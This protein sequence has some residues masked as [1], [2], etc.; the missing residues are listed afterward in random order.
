MSAAEM[1]PAAAAPATTAG[2]VLAASVDRLRSAG[3]PTPRLD[4]EVLVAWLFERDRAWL[5]AHLDEPV[6]TAG[7]AT[8]D[9]WVNRRGRGE[10][11]A[12][13]RGF[14][15]WNGIRLLTDERALIPRPETELLV[16]AAVAEIA[17]RLVRDERAISAWDVGT[18]SGAV[19]VAL[20]RRFRSAL[21]LGRVRL[22]ASDV[23]PEAVE[24]ASDNLVAH[25]VE[26][27]VTLAVGDLLDADRAIRPDVLVAN[28]P[29]VT[30]GEVATGEGSLGWEP[31]TALDGGPDGLDV[32]RSLFD[33]L[34]G[35]LAEDGT[36]LLEVGSDQA[37]QVRR[38]VGGLPGS[39]AVSVAPDLAGRDRVVHLERRP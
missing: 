23:S 6:E 10:P 24:L 13:I 16:E 39:W 17:A 34:P 37:D 20:A 36:A 26:H 35:R 2:Q 4:A 7:M 30:S 28:L 9:G 3:S 15:E 25:G 5:L 32:V 21:A 14:K 12:Y 33:A 18:G 27:L 29:Y 1:A 22:V 11:V 8:L 19:A 31:P 38:L